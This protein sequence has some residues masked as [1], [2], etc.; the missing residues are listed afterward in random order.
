MSPISRRAVALSRID[1][2]E[3]RLIWRPRVMIPAAGPFRSEMALFQNG[4][5][6]GSFEIQWPLG[7]VG[8]GGI[9]RA[10]PAWAA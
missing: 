4:A 9:A 3:G 6:V 5:R 8:I 7:T 1:M 10:I 2:K